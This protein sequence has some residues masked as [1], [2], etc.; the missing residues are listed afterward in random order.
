[1]H[2]RPNILVL[3]NESPDWPEHDKAWNARMTDLLTAALR[4]E[5]FVCQPA[6]IFDSLSVLDDYD[7]R[8]WL[9]WN[10]VEELGGQ[11]WTDGVAAAELEGRGFAFTGSSA[12][13]LA[14]SVDR[15]NIK[16]RLLEAGLPTLPARRFSQPEESR[17]WDDFPAIVKGA[18][19]H[20]SFGIDAGSV[21]QTPEQLAG[22]IAYMRATYNCDSLVERFLDTREFHVSV[23]GNGRAHALP[24]A[25]Y[26]YSVFDDIHDRLYTYQWKYDDKSY[27]YHALK[28]RC[29]SPMDD[30]A[31]RQ[32]LEEVSVGAYRALNLSDYGRV[33]IR[34]LDGQ[35]QILDVNANP[36]LADNSAFVASAQAGGLTYAQT[37]ARIV[38]HATERMSR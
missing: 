26:D 29:P 1:V 22:R 3:Y 28:L 14:L 37:M 34:L 12:A 16:Q 17:G 13:A 31:L 8:A 36:D 27:G 2:H 15:F 4:S 30:P 32:R 11:A 5:G 7:P 19:Q 35:P 18:T 21:V 20:G 25:E 33:D 10:W 38:A 24:P 6:K 23:L 9:V